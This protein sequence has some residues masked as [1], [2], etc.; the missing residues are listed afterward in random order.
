MGRKRLKEE[1]VVVQY[2]DEDG[3]ML[4]QEEVLVDEK[5]QA[6]VMKAKLQTQMTRQGADGGAGK[7]M[8]GGGNDD[9][10]ELTGD[11]GRSMDSRLGI[12]VLKSDDDDSDDDDLCDDKIRKKKRSKDRKKGA[13][14]DGKKKKRKHEKHRR[15]HKQRGKQE[16]WATFCYIPIFRLV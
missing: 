5:K 8:H 10:S 15:R 11:G 1:R 2:V 3:N 13:K 12:T 4:H 16:Q 14:S 6:K 7:G 9:F